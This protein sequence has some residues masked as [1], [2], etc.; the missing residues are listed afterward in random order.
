M[1]DEGI[2]SADSAAATAAHDQ[3]VAEALNAIRNA[4]HFI[5]STVDADGVCGVM[6]SAPFLFIAYT[7]RVLGMQSARLLAAE[8][9][10]MTMDELRDMMGG[11]Q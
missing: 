8:V 6:V 3:T 2:F 4:D 10:G 11:E 5:V 9:D 7:E 1:N